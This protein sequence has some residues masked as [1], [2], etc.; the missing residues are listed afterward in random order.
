MLTQDIAPVHDAVVYFNTSLL[1]SGVLLLTL[2]QMLLLLLMVCFDPY[3]TK[4][5]GRFCC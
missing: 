1:G 3:I 5:S 2:L 4:N